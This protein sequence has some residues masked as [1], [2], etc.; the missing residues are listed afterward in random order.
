MPWGKTL[1]GTLDYVTK[2]NSI[3]YDW[4]NPQPM[5]NFSKYATTMWN[6]HTW[7]KLPDLKWLMIDARWYELRFVCFGS[8]WNAGM[9]YW[10]MT[11]T[12]LE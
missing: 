1:V 3:F 2:S 7:L 8:I 6:K 9:T 10:S 11:P 5:S 12:A 4:K